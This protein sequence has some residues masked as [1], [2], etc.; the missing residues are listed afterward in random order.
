VAVASITNVPTSG[1][2]GNLTLYGTVNPSNATN[3]TI[4]WSIYSARTTGASISGNT[5]TTTAAGTVTVRATIANGAAQGTNYAQNFNITINPAGGNPS[6]ITYTVEQ[7][8]GVNNTTTTT[9]IVFNF[10]ASFNSLYLTA[11]DITL[12]GAASTNWSTTLT[13]TGTSRTLAPITINAPGL[14]TVSI[15]KTGIEATTKDVI[16]HKAGQATPEYWSINWHLNGGAEG[17]NEYPT[18]ILKGA[19]LVKPSPDPTKDDSIFRGWHTDSGLTQAYYFTS[20][21]IA[22][23]DLY[24][25]W[26]AEGQPPAEITV[27]GSTLAEKLQWIQDN[28]QSNTIYTIEV[29]ADEAIDPHEL[30]YTDKNAITI[31]LEGKGGEKVISLSQIES[32]DA[33]NHLFAVDSGVTLILDN[34]ITLQGDSIRLVVKVN[35]GGT[36]IMNTG[37][38]ISGGHGF[39]GGGGVYVDGGTFTMNDGEISGN[40]AGGYGGGGVYVDGGTFTMNGGEISNNTFSSQGSAYGGGVYVDNGTFT[41]TD[42]KI[43]GNTASS[44]SNSSSNSSNGGG[45]YVGSNGTFTMEG[46]EISDNN[47]TYSVTSS[48]NGGGVY[49]RNGGIFTMSDGEISGNTAYSGGG[50]YVGSNGTFTMEGGEIS[51]NTGGGVYNMSG[52]TFTMT[53][54]KISDNNSVNSSSGSGVYMGSG[55]FTMNDGEISGNTGGS[56]VYMASGTFTMSNGE[57]SGNT[58]GWGGGG[59]YVG[60][61]QDNLGTFTMESGEISGNIAN[62]R[63]GGVYVSEYGTFTMNNGEISGNTTTDSA[64]STYG[65]GGV[66]VGLYGTFTKSNGTIYGYSAGD[67]INSNVVKNSS[68]TVMSNKGHAVL[69]S[70]NDKRRETTAGPEVNLDSSKAG[71]E[72]G[73]EN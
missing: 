49:V 47:T 14:A 61:Y 10:S 33:L 11:D 9:G 20:P 54:G 39:R 2:V 6:G 21:V 17:M 50:V 51:G 8:G 18:Q 72:G 59:V 1:T 31:Q 16:V 48:R 22:D 43:S 4:V 68:G 32:W 73:W 37:A 40:T 62:V 58:G 5:L 13:G 34:N 55:T 3:S 63:G 57:I 64:N 19:V 52:V 71:A 65:G 53:G 38:K 67:T 26:E 29:N 36:L 28:A 12:G 42:G 7:I 70:S 46:G 25:K 66:Y 45:V 56:G 23:L 60:G 44:S 69:V 15:N 24:A 30:S 27:I 35:S 41:M